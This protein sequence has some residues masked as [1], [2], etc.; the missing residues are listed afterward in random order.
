[1]RGWKYTMENRDDAAAI[2][3]K[4]VPSLDKAIVRE[5]IDLLERVA[6]NSDVRQNG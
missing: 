2:M 3:V 4:A 1:M 5:E 6:I